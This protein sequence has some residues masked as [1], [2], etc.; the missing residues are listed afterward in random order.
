MK[1]IPLFLISFYRKI[2]FLFPSQCKYYPSCSFYAE[3]AFL[4]YPFFKALFLTITRIFRC[5][6][7][8]KGGYDPLP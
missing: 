2:S 8:S 6:P 3:K 5:H 7:L 1:A 4:R